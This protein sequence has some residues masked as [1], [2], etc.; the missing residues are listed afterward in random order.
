MGHGESVVEQTR[1][2]D[3]REVLGSNRGTVAI[4]FTPVCQCV[5]EETQ[6]ATP[7]LCETYHELNQ[8]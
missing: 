1:C 6:K 7:T 5:S 2:T 4:R 3:E 8:Y